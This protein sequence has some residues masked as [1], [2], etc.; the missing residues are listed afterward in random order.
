MILD[1]VGRGTSTFDGMAI[2][3][4]IIEYIFSVV[5]ARCLF[6]THYHELTHLQNVFPGIVNYYTKCQRNVSG[7]SF[8]HK[9]A[10][11]ASEGSFGIEVAKLACLPA[12]IIARAR[13]LLIAMENDEKTFI[14]ACFSSDIAVSGELKKLLDENE[15]L[16]CA[17]ASIQ[18]VDLDD[19]TPRQA[20]KLVCNLRDLVPSG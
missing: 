16:K 19:L 20:H 6:A 5:K 9:L 13:E 11:G 15:R 17:I 1:E 14:P 7:M 18:A 10:Q 2:A 12:K 8:I 3:Q 4:A